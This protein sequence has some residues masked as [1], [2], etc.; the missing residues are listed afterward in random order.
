M[1]EINFNDV[2][3]IVFPAGFVINRADF[4][5]CP[6]SSA[7]SFVTFVHARYV[8]LRRLASPFVFYFLLIVM[9]FS[10]RVIHSELLRHVAG[11]RS[12]SLATVGYCN[13]RWVS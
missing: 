1:N 12:L 5:T 10:Q 11:V 6:P 4:P 2:I 9:Q 3:R 7:S 13:G 8:F